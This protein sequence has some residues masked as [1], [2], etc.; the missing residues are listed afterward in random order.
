MAIKR[1]TKPPKRGLLQS[2]KPYQVIS[3]K[4][5]RLLINKIQ[6]RFAR[7]P[8]DERIEKWNSLGAELGKLKREMADKRQRMGMGKQA[9]KEP[10]AFQEAI[11]KAMQPYFE[12]MYRLQLQLEALEPLL[13][14][15]LRE[16]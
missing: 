11:A 12:R 10:N 5:K 13:S 14:E 8:Q 2:H 1:S 6:A 16:E 3:E 4:R 15:S 7:L 9:E